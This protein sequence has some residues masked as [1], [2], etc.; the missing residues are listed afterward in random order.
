MTTHFARED[1]ETATLNDEEYRSESPGPSATW[2]EHAGHS[3]VEPGAPVGG[4]RGRDV[5]TQREREI[6]IAAKF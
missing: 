4:G 5:S 6:D 1:T 3:C 2:G